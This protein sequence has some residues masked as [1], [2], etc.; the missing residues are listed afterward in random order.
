MQGKQSKLLGMV[1]SV[2]K[3]YVKPILLGPKC[4]FDDISLLSF[5]QNNPWQDLRERDSSYRTSEDLATKDEALGC[6]MTCVDLDDVPGE[7]STKTVD[8]C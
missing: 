8:S 5:S 2:G 1:Y 6:S 4:F 3:L 7:G